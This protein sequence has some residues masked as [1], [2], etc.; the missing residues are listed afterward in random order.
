MVCIAAGIVATFVTRGVL[1]RV[2]V[3]YQL[4]PLVLIYPCLTVFFCFVFWLMF[5]RAR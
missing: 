2:D 3:E 5:F 4:A 1:R